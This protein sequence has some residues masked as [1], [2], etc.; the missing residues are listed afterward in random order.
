MLYVRL[1]HLF[2]MSLWIGGAVATFVVARVIAG[3]SIE[4]RM[5][6]LPLLA[7]LHAL[8][9][10][11]GAIATVVSGVLITMSMVNR[12]MSEA[13]ARPGIVVMQ[14]AGILAAILVVFVGVPTANR[15]AVRAT[16][17]RGGEPHPVVSALRR[18]QAI[19]SSIAG[20]LALI[21]LFFAVV[22]R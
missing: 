4:E 3:W 7:K 6:A 16:M 13:M 22:V 8:V 19:V 18:R 9:I 17:T 2:G 5:R 10:A 1:V 11:P 20:V 12:G 15:L 21:A 14:A